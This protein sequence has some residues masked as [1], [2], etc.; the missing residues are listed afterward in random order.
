MPRVFLT[1]ALV[2]VLSSASLVKAADGLRE[3]PF[4]GGN[5]GEGDLMTFN[6]PGGVGPL[7]GIPSLLTMS[8]DR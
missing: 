4:P 1:L 7:V 8:F 2:L 6:A 5:A 3:P